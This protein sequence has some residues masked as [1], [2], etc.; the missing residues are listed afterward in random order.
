MHGREQGPAPVQMAGLLIPEDVTRVDSYVA[1]VQAPMWP[2]FRLSRTD[3]VRM[4]MCMEFDSLAFQVPASPQTAS[5]RLPTTRDQ[6]PM[7]SNAVASLWHCSTST[8]TG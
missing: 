8:R 4:L 1:R 2:G 6:A 5:C 7:L 3:G